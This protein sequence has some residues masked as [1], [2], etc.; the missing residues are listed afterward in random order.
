MDLGADVVARAVGEGFGESGGADDVAR[1][2][3]GLPSCEGLLRRVGGLDGGDG[4]VA[5]MRTVVKMVC[6][7]WVGGRRRFR[8]R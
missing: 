6:S 2:V 3:V 7:R 5:G 4:G 1:G 8:R